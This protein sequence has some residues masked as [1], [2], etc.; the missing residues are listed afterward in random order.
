MS[1]PVFSSATFCRQGSPKY[2]QIRLSHRALLCERH[3]IA[4]IISNNNLIIWSLF[5]IF[6]KEILNGNQTG[7]FCVDFIFWHEIEHLR[8]VLKPI[9]VNGCQMKG[10]NAQNWRSEYL[11]SSQNKI[12]DNLCI[13]ICRFNRHDRKEKIVGTKIIYAS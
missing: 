8:L 3:Y 11:K 12:K 9:T 1:V 7:R 2:P 5:Y 10:N 13:I 6:S 4:N